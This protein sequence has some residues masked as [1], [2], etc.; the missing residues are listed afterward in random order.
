M[1]GKSGCIVKK[2]PFYKERLKFYN[3]NEV[4]YGVK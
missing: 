2:K 1:N 4:F 3:E